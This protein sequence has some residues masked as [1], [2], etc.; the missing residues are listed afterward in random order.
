MK[1]HQ[2]TDQ[3]RIE[4]LAHRI[5]LQEKQPTGQAGVHWRRAEEALRNLDESTA[6]PRDGRVADQRKRATLQCSGHAEI[7]GH[8]LIYRD[9]PDEGGRFYPANLQDLRMPLDL[10]ATLQLDESA[11]TFALVRLQPN[12]DG[13]ACFD[14]AFQE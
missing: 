2:H 12:T 1:D 11:E 10:P 3:E 4:G 7:P 9:R 5:Y 13:E 14:I 6:S 8:A